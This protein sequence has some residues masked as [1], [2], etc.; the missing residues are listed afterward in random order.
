[1]N[2]F[3]RFSIRTA[4]ADDFVS[5]DKLFSESY[6]VLLREAYSE[7]ICVK[8]LPL[9]SRA[10]PDLVR[11]GKFFLVHRGSKLVGAGGWTRSAPGTGLVT[12]GIGHVRHVVSDHRLQRQGIG[13]RLLD[14]VMIN[15]QGDGLGALRCLST[16]NAVPFYSAMGF[17]EDGQVDVQLPGGVSFPA[18]RMHA[19]L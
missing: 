6:P 7:E 19:T 1:M 18:I 12:P 16:L 5:V 8:A 17:V 14:Y 15:A 3:D 2:S 11:S 4:Q 10:Q 9:I 13:R